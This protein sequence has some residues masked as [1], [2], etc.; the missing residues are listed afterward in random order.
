MS[1]GG[2]ASHDTAQVSP[3]GLFERRLSVRVALCIAAGV[4]LGLAMPGLF[5]AVAANEAAHVNLLVAT[6]CRAARFCICFDI[7]QTT[8]GDPGDRAP[9]RVVP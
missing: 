2:G 8:F 9:C 6:T 5:R 4:G 7:C 3:L 1:T